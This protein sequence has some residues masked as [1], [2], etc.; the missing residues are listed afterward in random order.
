[1]SPDEISP[2]GHSVD[3]TFISVEA[4]LCSRPCSPPPTFSSILSLSSRFTLSPFY[5]LFSCHVHFIILP[6]FTPL[7]PPPPPPLFLLAHLDAPSC[8]CHFYQSIGA[9]FVSFSSCCLFK[10]GA[11]GCL[12]VL[13]FLRGRWQEEEKLVENDMLE[14]VSFSC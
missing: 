14:A 12:S 2:S 9:F 5:H 8:L 11:R 13:V 7:P 1:M 3:T 4:H 6:V 10:Q